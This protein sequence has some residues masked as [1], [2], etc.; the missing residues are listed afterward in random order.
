MKNI[1][2]MLTQ[3]MLYS[4]VATVI[5]AAVGVA[6]LFQKGAFSDDR[7]LHMWAALHGISVPGESVSVGEPASQD[8]PSYE[9]ILN[10][11]ALA[12]L[13]LDLRENTLD[14]SLREMRVIEAT[15]RTEQDRF[16]K[17]VQSF[18]GEIKRLEAN[19]TDAA[20]LETQVTLEA[21]P[22]KQAKQQLLKLLEEPPSP[23]IENPMEAVVSLVK[24]MPID[25][26]K[27]ILSEFK[28]PEEEGK[29]GEILREFLRG[30]PDVP[31]LREAREELQ[32]LSAVP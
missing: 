1:V 3:L 26:R 20:V 10:R 22:P 11:R 31:L 5:A 24:A 14:K 13:D 15:V 9:E 19:A 27:K 6:M 7:V 2:G 18:D 25:K 23:G 30:S 28:S 4:C 32:N 12:A 21:L 16:D 17:L 8:M 29:L